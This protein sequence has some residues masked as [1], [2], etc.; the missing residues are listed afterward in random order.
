MTAVILIVMVLLTPLLQ[1]ATPVQGI[2]PNVSPG[3]TIETT[4]L[5]DSY[6]GKY[7]LQFLSAI[8]DSAYEWTLTA[9]VLPDG[10]NLDPS[11]IISGISSEVGIWEF[12]VTVNDKVSKDLSINILP[13]V[14]LVEADNYYELDNGVKVFRFGKNG[15]NEIW[16]FDKSELL[17]TGEYWEL[18][19][20]G[21]IVDPKNVKV[22]YVEVTPDKYLVNQEYKYTSGVSYI[23]TYIVE[24]AQ[25][26]IVEVEVNSKK[27]Q[28]Y[29]LEWH[30]DN[31]AD[32]QLVTDGIKY[33]NGVKLS[34]GDV[35]KTLGDIT[36]VDTQNKKVKFNLGS[37]EDGDSLLLDPIIED[38]DPWWVD[39]TGNWSDAANHWSTMSAY[40]V[41]TASF[42]NGST[43]VEGAGGCDWTTYSGNQTKALGGTWYTVAS[44]TDADTLE[45]SAP[46][47][48]ASTGAVSYIIANPGAGN[49]PGAGSPVWFDANSFTG[50]GQVVTLD[51]A[52]TCLDMI[53][54]GATNTPTLAGSSGVGV[55]GNLTFIAAMNITATGQLSWGKDAT[56]TSLTTNG[57]TLSFYNIYFYTSG[58]KTL[59]D[60]LTT[61]GT[62]TYREGT[63]DTN[64]QTVTCTTFKRLA[65]DENIVTL[66]FGTSVI[67]CTS[68]TM[69]NSTNLT[70][71]ANTAT[72]NISGTGTL[73]GGNADYNGADF[74]LNSTAHAVSGSFTCAVLTRNGTATK[75][76]TV[77]FTSGDTVTCTTFAMIGNS[78]TNR[79]LVQSS[80]LGTPAT[81]TATNWTGTDTCDIMDIIATNAVDLS[82]AAAYTG[83]CGGNTGITFTAAAAQ[84]WDGTTGSWSDNTKWT[85]RVPL[86]QD[87]VSAGGAGNTITVDMPR[88]GKSVTFTGTPA[89]TLSNDVNN[90]GSLTLVSG[91]AA[92]TYAGNSQY[93]R[94]RGAYTVTTAGNDLYR[95]YVYAPGGLY[96]LQDEATITGWLRVEYGSWDFND[97]DAQVQILYCSY[98]TTRE[99]HLGN[100]TITLYNTAADKW[101]ITDPTNLTFAAEGSTIIL[102]NTGVAAQNF[103][104][105]GL[106]Y[107]DV[108]VA[109][110]GNYALTITAANTFATF[111]VDA[112]SA[113]KT[114]T[115]VS[116]QTVDDFTRDE[117]GTNIITINGAGNTWTKSDATDILLDYLHITNSTANP[118]TTWYAGVHSTDNGGNAGWVFADG[119]LTTTTNAAT[120]ITMDKDGVT[121]SVLNGTITTLAGT[122]YISTW[123]DYGLTGAYGSTTAAV[124]KYS[125]GAYSATL[126]TNLTPGATY[127]FRSSVSTGAG[128]FVGADDTF[129]FTMPTVTTGTATIAASTVVLNGSLATMGVASDVYSRFEYGTTAGMGSFT[130][131]QTLAGTGDFTDSVSS[132]MSD[133]TIYYRSV[134]TVGSVSTYGVASEVSV[135]GAAGG[136]LIKALLRFIVAAS[137]L[138]TVLI[139]G[140][141]GS[142]LGLLLSSV[143]GLIAFIVIDAYISGL[144]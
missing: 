14:I 55:S 99:L 63:I 81:I 97:Q 39:G 24:Y 119:S 44:V 35:K 122:P 62:I 67:N 69:T 3:I 42:V 31:D 84:T 96:T 45:L 94:G 134:T 113:A 92:W 73:A 88:I 76:D 49:L 77:T 32:Y 128:T 22:T 109:G 51:A 120:G 4:G 59:V 102:T 138:I 121:G 6:S 105:G 5:P 10:L 19:Q 29:A 86:P 100:G 131:A 130:A 66:T 56:V 48:E 83:D 57:K 7:Y 50:A 34:W 91:G 53:W 26:T 64:G 95:V 141:R 25:E 107:N 93:L 98:T 82:G 36:T 40:M 143:L 27:K 79:L 129:T 38:A 33:T 8:G 16:A 68:F 101:V 103:A 72:I 115:T 70:V 127:H 106:T 136:F 17:V 142:G 61:T 43:T 104:G 9:G 47:G 15:K 65:A 116:T 85:S 89:V 30:A 125:Y 123:F 12:T 11:G 58:T 2:E 18:L 117:G 75:T 111:D 137:I 41:G 28:G 140:I 124:N 90:Y 54:T 144:F 46:F 108:T 114:I 60:A 126:P 37:I 21:V 13:I 139:V 20:D 112:S 74:N 71:T 87:D 110:A 135:P 133:T 118:A 52:A 80:I 23:S 78:A 132:P 1:V